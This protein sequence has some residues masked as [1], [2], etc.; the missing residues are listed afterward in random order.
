MPLRFSGWAI[1]FLTL[2]IALIL[3]ILP[4]PHWAESFR[5]AWLLLVVL[6]WVIKLPHRVNVGI[7]WLLG[8]MLDV[9]Q[10]TLLGENA[11]CFSLLAYFAYRMCRQIR[12]FSLPMQSLVMFAFL[13]LNQILLFWFQGMQGEIVTWKWFFG[14]GIVSAL[15]WPWIFIVL[16]DCVKRYRL[17]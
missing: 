5:P 17:Y 4:L 16:T 2:F 7:A 11:L 14:A 1:I 13:M 10:G 3:M 12:L 6:Y 8:I 15:I 9:L